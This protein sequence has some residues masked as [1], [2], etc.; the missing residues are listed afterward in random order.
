MHDYTHPVALELGGFHLTYID[1]KRNVWRI[2]SHK[3]YDVQ[4]I[5]VV[6]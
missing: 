2:N 5:H 1:V 3:S 6:Q 4:Y